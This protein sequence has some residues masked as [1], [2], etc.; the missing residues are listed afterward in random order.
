MSKDHPGP[1]P[2]GRLATP[3]EFDEP[4]EFV[5]AEHQ[6]QLS[7]CDWD[8]EFIGSLGFD[9]VPEDA[10]ALLKILMRDLPLRAD[11]RASESGVNRVAGG[12]P[13]GGAIL[14]PSLV[15]GGAANAGLLWNRLDLCHCSSMRPAVI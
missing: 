12:S 5:R 10:T 13:R 9:P 11:H 3:V 2:V 1:F 7:V 14:L 8:G 15:N 4:L 6:R